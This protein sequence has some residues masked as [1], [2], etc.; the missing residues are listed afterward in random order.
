MKVPIQTQLI[1]GKVLMRR[2]N[3]RNQPNRLYLS[4]KRHPPICT[5]WARAGGPVRITAHIEVQLFAIVPDIVGMKQLVNEVVEITLP[6]LGDEYEL[7]VYGLTALKCVTSPQ[8]G[9]LSPVSQSQS[10]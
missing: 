10:Y 9:A 3:R 5:K 1:D 2:H 4:Q 6:E 8:L 7:V